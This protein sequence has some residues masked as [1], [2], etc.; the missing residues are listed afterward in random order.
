MKNFSRWFPTF[1][2]FFQNT[3]LLI[4]WF[5]NPPPNSRKWIKRTLFLAII[6]G[7]IFAEKI[8]WSQPFTKSCGLPRRGEAECIPST[9]SEA[10]LLFV[11]FI[12]AGLI[13]W[14]FWDEYQAKKK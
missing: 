1:S 2:M 12:I 6:S 10:F 13:A 9:G 4:D 11:G 3:R 7:L 5:F 14:S 8:Q